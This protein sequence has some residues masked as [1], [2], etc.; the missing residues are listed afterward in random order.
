MNSTSIYVDLQIK[1]S[2]QLRYHVERV[3]SVEDPLRQTHVS[4][5]PL[6]H[7]MATQ[8]SREELEYRRTLV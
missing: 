7:G 4:D 3:S 5:G 1:A 8:S 6:Q 2:R